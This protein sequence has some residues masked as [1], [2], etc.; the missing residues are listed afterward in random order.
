[1]Q[2]TSRTGNST[3]FYQTEVP[4]FKNLQ[5]VLI[6][7]ENSLWVRYLSMAEWVENG[8]KSSR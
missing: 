3:I 5:K 8:G 2:R 4:K 6:V 7:L 1:L